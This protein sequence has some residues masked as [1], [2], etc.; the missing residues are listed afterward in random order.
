MPIQRSTRIKVSLVVPMRDEEGSIGRLIDS[1]RQQERQPDE[2]LLVDGGSTD[3]TVES[4]RMLTEDDYRFRVIPAGEATPGRGR[5]VGVAASSNEWI[6]F[7]DAG[8]V[9][10][11][12][13]L[14]RLI[15]VAERDASISVVYGDYEPVT[16]T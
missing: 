14:G 11:S 16:D 9:L 13:W 4:A 12:A 8:I 10:E 6:A 2:V 15:D 3:K 5:N 1:I 7:T